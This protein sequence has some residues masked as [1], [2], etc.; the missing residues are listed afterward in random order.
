[1]DTEES[2]GANP[3]GEELRAQRKA[4]GWT[5]VEAG[6]KLGWSDSFI[7]DVERRDKTPRSD[8]AR[9]CDEIFGCPGTF[10]RIHGMVRFAAYPSF[11]APAL[12]YETSAARIHGW[13]L[14]SV[15]GL[16][17]TEDYARALISATRPQDS[18]ARIERLVSARMQRQEVLDG[19]NA[20]KV[21][22]VIDE[23]VLR[24]VVGSSAVMDAQIDQLLVWARTPGIVI[25]VLPLAAGDPAGTDG[26][27]VAYE[28]A[29][30][31]SVVYS[32]CNRGGRLVE[33]PAE[34]AELMTTIAAVRASALSP[35]ATLDMLR[36]LG[37][38]HD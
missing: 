30:R 19:E 16:F 34:V 36:N 21:W 25:Q 20:P 27:I 28:F 35:R 15:P 33:E 1:M 26:P 5:Q 10:E 18:A 12:P 2:Q 7:S 13:E 38:E 31:P 22:Y 14:G 23:G 37:R 32:E 3:L 6:E 11:F 29:D 4:R 17:Q 8:F 9:K 24:R